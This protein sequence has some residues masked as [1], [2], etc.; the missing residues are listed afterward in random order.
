MN[1]MKRYLSLVCILGLLPVY[2]VMGQQQDVVQGQVLNAEGN[3]VGDAVVTV[4]G[5]DGEPMTQATTDE[6]GRFSVRAKEG[7]RL[8][9]EAENYSD[10]T[11][12][13]Q[14]REMT[15]TLGDDGKSIALGYG[16]TRERDELTAAV[17]LARA[18]DFAD[19]PKMSMNAGNALY[20][21]LP[22][23][24]VLENSGAPPTNP[25]LFIRGRSTFSNSDPLI[26]VDGFRRPL[27]S[28]ALEEIQSVKVL[29]DAAALAKFGQEG[30]NGVLLVTTKRGNTDGLQVNASLNMGLTEPTALPEMVGA[31]AYA[32]AVNEARANDGLSPR[33]SPEDLQG[34]GSEGSSALYPNVDFFDE[35]LRERGVRSK[36]NLSFQGGGDRARYYTML[37]YVR[38]S[39]LFGPVNANE[40]YNTQLKYSRFRFR[41]NLDVDLTETLLLQS[42]V[43]ANIVE[44]NLPSGGGGGGADQIFDALYTLPSAAYPVRTPSGAF[45]GRSGYPQ[46]PMAVLTATGYGQPN[47]RE[48]SLTGRLRQD[49]NQFLEGLSAEMTI[50]YNNYGSFYENQDRSFAYESLDLVRNQD[51]EILDTTATPLG[52]A[53]DLSYSSGFSNKRQFTHLRG[54]L[55]YAR[56]LGAHS[57]EATAMFKQSSRAFDGRDAINHRRNFFGNVHAGIA[58]KYFVDVSVSYG[59]NNRVPPDGGRYEVYPA[60]S[61]SWVLSR[62]NF[63]REVGVLDL[64][65]LQASWGIVGSDD[66]PTANPWER[67]Y[68]FAEGYRF[69]NDN[70]FW[71]GMSEQHAPTSGFGVETSQKANV[72]LDAAFLD[73]RLQLTTDFFYTRRSNILASGDGRYSFIL[74]TFPPDATNGLVENRGMEASLRWQDQG[75]DWGYHIGGTFSFARNK[76]LEQN[77]VFRQEDY[78]RRT[79]E[80][81][82]QRFGLEA[83]GFFQDEEEIAN[84]PEQNFGEVKPGDIKYKDQNG[85]GLI[86]ELDEVPMGYSSDYPEMY[87]ASSLG[88]SYKGVSVSALFQGTANYTAYLNTPGVFRPMTNNNTISTHYYNRRW[89]PATAGSATYPRLSTEE[90]SNNFRPN[91]V[92]LT[93]RSYVKLR[94]L[95]VSYSL[96]SSVVNSMKLDKLQIVLRGRNLFSID[97]IPV[98]DP[99]HL[100]SGYPILRSYSAGI[101]VQ[102]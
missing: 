4:K 83:I 22:G 7:R 68:D 2:T 75:E 39:G 78:L 59:G 37:N 26:L 29:K 55:N 51:G 77:E 30:A 10:E 45:G 70:N 67:F 44:R 76:I 21:Q 9:V 20:G 12:S 18:S 69:T 35:V 8:Q 14:D 95:K 42:D 82:G 47:S 54:Q 15:V 49:M 80:P 32:Q 3:S 28:V 1:R 52:E 93:D 36:F 41:T 102:L 100:S 73:Q 66:L 89:T 24:M 5:T 99:E 64:L 74:G 71:Q 92:W 72:G 25:T 38:D 79:G 91:S 27:S 50:N 65:K 34:F 57:L 31:R 58:N 98:L 17:G 46:N 11:V 60:V 63:L 101:E 33:Y 61:A 87:F 53:T 88:A 94:S 84:S 96:P 48:F 40:D 85:D 90:N 62:E 19:A 56:S 86:N 6:E 97:N 81:V 16:I 43:T 13:I 23:L